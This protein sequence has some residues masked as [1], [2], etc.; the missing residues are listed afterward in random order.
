VPHGRG[1]FDAEGAE[2]RGELALGDRWEWLQQAG[3]AYCACMVGSVER[4]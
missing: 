1:D 4:D 3:A 2:I